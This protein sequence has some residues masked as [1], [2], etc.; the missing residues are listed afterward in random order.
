L[1]T[2]PAGDPA[3][4]AAAY[5]S[6]TVTSGADGRPVLL[7]QVGHDASPAPLQTTHH[8]LPVTLTHVHHHLLL[9]QKHTARPALEAEMVDD[10]LA[11][12]VADD[13]C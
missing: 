3:D 7:L 12:M 13:S 4:L 1:I 6:G 2:V 10:W 5:C 8:S 11:G 9:Q